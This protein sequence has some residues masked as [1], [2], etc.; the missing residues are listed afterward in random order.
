VKSAVGRELVGVELVRKGDVTILNVFI[1][2][3]ANSSHEM[4]KEITMPE[5]LVW[6]A[7]KL[8][9]EQRQ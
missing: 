5:A 1:N 4:F 6:L 3:I 2:G 7:T 9:M 8:R